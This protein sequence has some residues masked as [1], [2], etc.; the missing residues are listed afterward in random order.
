MTWREMWIGFGVFVWIAGYIRVGR[1]RE[2]DVLVNRTF[3]RPPFFIYLLCGMPKA[4]NIPK[5]VMAIP[6]VFA[7]LQGIFWLLFGLTNPDLNIQKPI[8]QEIT[9]LIGTI[10]IIVYVWILYKRNEYRI[11]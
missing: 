2:N 9:F 8:I 3:V 10:S 11:D 6:S 5:G 4:R 7:Q 1:V